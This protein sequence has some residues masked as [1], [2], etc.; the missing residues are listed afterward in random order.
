MAH[1]KAISHQFW[2]NALR[3]ECDRWRGKEM[4]GQAMDQLQSTYTPLIL[5][6][7]EDLPDNAAILEIGSGPVCISKL[8]PQGEKTYVDPLLDDYRRTFPGEL[9]EGEM[10]T[11][12]GES[13][14]K[15]DQSFD[16]VICIN[17]LGFV[18]NPELVLNEVD[19]LLRPG[20]AMLIGMTVFSQLEARIHYWLQRLYPALSPEDRPYCYSLH[21]IRKT[22]ARHFDIREDIR[23]GYKPGPFP[24]I[25]REERFFVCIRP[26]PEAD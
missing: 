3:I 19:R 15:P 21:G 10:I 22:L 6:Y 16:C 13:I 8:I 11:A 25:R 12:M 7:T 2:Q 9:P 14:P 1:H 26:K 4:L 20:G 24:G 5:K 17:A 23:V 18:M